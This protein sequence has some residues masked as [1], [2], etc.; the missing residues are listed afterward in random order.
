M[1]IVRGRAVL[2]LLINVI[3]C[4]NVC[5]EIVAA[6]IPEVDDDVSG[7]TSA[8]SVTSLVVCATTV[9]IM[10]VLTVFIIARRKRLL[11]SR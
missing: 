3:Q 8:I 7:M 11:S 1:H 2:M 10:I 5:I 9:V 6:G 4:I